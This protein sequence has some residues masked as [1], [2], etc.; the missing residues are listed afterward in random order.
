MQ[1]ITVDVTKTLQRQMLGSSMSERMDY[2][3]RNMGAT[4]IFHVLR[5]HLD[6]SRGM[7]FFKWLNSETCMPCVKNRTTM[8]EMV[9]KLTGVEAQLETNVEARN[10]LEETCRTLQSRNSA[11]AVQVESMHAE[12]RHFWC[13]RRVQSANASA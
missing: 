4:Q 6:F 9:D 5:R 10:E 3:H 8:A 13:A 7:A 11:L 2:L 12:F 1:Q